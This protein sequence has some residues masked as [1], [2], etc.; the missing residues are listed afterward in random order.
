[1]LVA[2]RPTTLAMPPHIARP[3]HETAVRLVVKS[4]VK[5]GTI[6][7]RRDH[8]HSGKRLVVKTTVKAGGLVNNHV[9]RRLRV[10]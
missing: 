10:A 7:E 4:A 9:A 8:Q 6:L 3:A 1:M 2:M 5:A